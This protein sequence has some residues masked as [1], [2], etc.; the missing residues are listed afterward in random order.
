VGSTL[1]GKWHTGDSKFPPLS[2]SS[3]TA[4]LWDTE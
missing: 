1:L 2:L 4:I 3:S